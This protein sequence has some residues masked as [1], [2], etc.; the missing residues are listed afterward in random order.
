[1]KLKAR[2]WLMGTEVAK[3]LI[4]RDTL[5]KNFVLVWNYRLSPHPP[6]QLVHL[7][8][9]HSTTLCQSVSRCNTEV[10]G[11]GEI[12]ITWLKKLILT[13]NHVCQNRLVGPCRHQS[14]SRCSE[15]NMSRARVW[16]ALAGRW[17]RKESWC[18]ESFLNS[19]CLIIS[20]M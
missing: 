4:K 2:L 7:R 13:M 16:A 10:C 19:S 6:S 18:S 14:L 15:R 11:K 17:S 9:V 8:G 12:A 3:P 20:L 1:M 5:N